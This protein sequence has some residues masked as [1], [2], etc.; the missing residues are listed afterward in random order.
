VEISFDKL[1]ADMEVAQGVVLNER[2]AFE[3]KSN[4]TT[5]STVGTLRVD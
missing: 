3:V 2:L 1:T 4:R 5:G